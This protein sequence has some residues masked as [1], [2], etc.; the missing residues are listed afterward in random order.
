MYVSSACI[1][2]ALPPFNSHTP[3]LTAQLDGKCR[4][5]IY[6]LAVPALAQPMVFLGRLLAQL[7]VHVVLVG[8]TF[9]PTPQMDVRPLP[10][11]TEH[12]S[13]LAAGSGLGVRT[14]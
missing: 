14:D 5:D 2:H 8:L 9:V 4:G 7:L 6:A 1:I 11:W 12:G 10:S 3:D 13:D